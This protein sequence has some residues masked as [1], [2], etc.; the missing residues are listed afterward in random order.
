[1][2]FSKAK[3]NRYFIFNIKISLF[4]MVFETCLHTNI[5]KTSKIIFF[6]IVNKRVL[7]IVHKK[8]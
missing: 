3:K 8:G 6:I 2:M 4:N 5:T 7:S 1:M